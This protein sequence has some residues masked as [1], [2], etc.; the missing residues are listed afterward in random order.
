MKV[1]ENM[2]KLDETNCCGEL[3]YLNQQLSVAVQDEQN[4]PSTG[5]KKNSNNLKHHLV[6][7]DMN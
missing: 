6:T 2:M 7:Q 3:V 5:Q 1:D 4:P